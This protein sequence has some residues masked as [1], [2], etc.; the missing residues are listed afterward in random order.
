MPTRR[1]YP[2]K[3][4]WDLPY[5]GI[6]SRTMSYK[7]IAATRGTFVLPPTHAILEEQPELAGLSGGGILRVVESSPAPSL[8]I[9]SQ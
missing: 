5:L 6:S 9:A 8:H 7:A 1:I 4:V 3:V 2:D